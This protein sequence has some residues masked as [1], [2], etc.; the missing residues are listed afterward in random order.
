MKK[1]IITSVSMHNFERYLKEDEK[2][3]ATISKYMH[4]LKCFEEYAQ[5]HHIEKSLTMEYKDFLK[6]RYAVTSANSMLAA[7]NSYLR[8][9]GWHDC[10]VKQFKIQ[11]RAYCAE[12]DELTKEE[13]IRLLEAAKKKN[14]ERL[15]MLLQTICCTG[16]RISELQ[17]ITVESL[18]RGEAE[19]NCKGK[20]R[21]IFIVHDLCEK[22]YE[23][24]VKQR[25]AE[26]PVFVTEKGNPMN[27]SNIWR[28]M[29]SLCEDAGVRETKVYP[30]NLR[31]LFAR[32][33]YGI[34][35]DISK[36]AD[37]LGH[38]NINTTRIYIIS[39]GEEHKKKMEQMGLVI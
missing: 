23:Y 8:F 1:R 7:M 20:I 38:T 13:Y 37:V 33:F 21:R 28:E 27:R 24:T 15:Y 35:K 10:C 32:T 4:D 34:E 29:K 14:N 22:L 19:V 2:S 30:H 31:H 11:R 5:G 25:I 16:I 18:E 36:L 3:D 26:G 12:D 17:Y 39:T 6:E 9:E